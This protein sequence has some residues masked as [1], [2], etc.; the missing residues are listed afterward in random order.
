MKLL[1]KAYPPIFQVG[2]VPPAYAAAVSAIARER[3][4]LGNK[5]ISWAAAEKICYIPIQGFATPIFYY[6]MLKRENESE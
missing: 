6:K 1:N 3:A 4:I 5:F 2:Y